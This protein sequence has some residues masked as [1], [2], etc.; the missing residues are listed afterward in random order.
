MST[1]S[2]FITRNNDSKSDDIIKIVPVVGDSKLFQVTYADP[3]DGNVM[4]YSFT[5]NVNGVLDYLET[6][7]N[8]LQKDDEPFKSIQFN[9]PA[10]PRIMVNLEKLR[11]DDFMESLWRAISSVC[12][13]WPLRLQNT[14][15]EEPTASHR[16]FDSY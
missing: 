6:T 13:D 5:A 12:N 2:I 16:Y 9:L 8:L 4:K 14:V 15:V 1:I 10:Y 7:T 3:G 11:D